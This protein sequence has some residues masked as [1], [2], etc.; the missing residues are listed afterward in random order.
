VHHRTIQINHQ[1][2]AK[3]FQYILHQVG[4]LFELNVKLRCQKVKHPLSFSIGNTVPSV[5]N[6]SL[7]M[8]FVVSHSEHVSTLRGLNTGIIN[9]QSGGTCIVTAV[10]YTSGAKPFIL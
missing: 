3:N 9:V 5:T 4:D 7:L 8:L 10:L 2:D 1:L 6:T